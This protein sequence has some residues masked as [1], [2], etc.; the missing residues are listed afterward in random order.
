MSTANVSTP[1]PAGLT[2]ETVISALHNHELMIKTLCP[3]LISYEF[4]SGDKTSQAVYMV[5]DKKPLGQVNTPLPLVTQLSIPSPTSY[6]YTAI[7]CHT[8]TSAL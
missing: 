8:N 3:Q 1:L 7:R 6:L 4:E 5:T 2:Q